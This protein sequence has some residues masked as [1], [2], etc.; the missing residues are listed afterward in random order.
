VTPQEAAD[1][2][3][4]YSLGLA[5]SISWPAR[6]SSVAVK[7][8]REFDARSTFEGYSVQLSAAVAF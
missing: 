2:Y 4:V 6:R 8:F 1:H 7:L 3:R 5:S